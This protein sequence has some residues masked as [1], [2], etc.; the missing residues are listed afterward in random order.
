MK[1]SHTILVALLSFVLFTGQ[2]SEDVMKSFSTF[3]KSLSDWMQSVE[4]LKGRIAEV[5]KGL[6]GGL[7]GAV[8]DRLS[9]INKNINSLRTE[10]TDMTVRINKIETTLGG[11][12]NPMVQFGKTLDVLKKGVSDLGKK[13]EDQEVVTA[14]LEKRYQEYMRPL[15]PIKKDIT[16][17]QEAI[18][19]LST[20]LELQQKNT[21]ILQTTIVEKL[22]ALDTFLATSQEQLDSLS[23]LLVRV[24]N[25]EKGTGIVPPPE[26]VPKEVAEAAAQEE[27]KP[28]TPEEEG[29]EAIGGGFY[30]RNVQFN[31]FGSSAEIKG[32]LKNLSETNYG[33]ATFTIRVFDLENSPITNQDFTV[34]G[35][36][37]NDIKFFKEIVTGVEPTKISKYTIK[38]KGTY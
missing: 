25:L 5:E 21:E 37:S 10:L 16:Q 6:Q 20:G 33:L 2:K 8:M 15:D 35:F 38:F 9:E 1:K 28:K 17:N 3:E 12:E 36:G 22:S 30:L 19:K 18:K 31:P 11:G 27:V 13:I 23:R 26:L 32:E 34:K 7:G 29:Y 24:E 14:V 4:A